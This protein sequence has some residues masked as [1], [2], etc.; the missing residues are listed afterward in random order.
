MNLFFVATLVTAGAILLGLLFAGL[1]YSLSGVALRTH[2]EIEAHSRSGGRSG[3]LAGGGP[4]F[5]PNVPQTLSA[6]L[7][8]ARVAAARIAA[9]VP[10]FGN[11]GIGRLE[12]T[13][14]VAD[15]KVA[16]IGAASGNDPLTATRIAW[17]HTRAGLI[18]VRPTQPGAAP[19]PAAT[20]AARKGAAPAANLPPAPQLIEITDSMPPEEVRK[21][22]IAN[23]KAKSAYNKL[24]KGMGVELSAAEPAAEVVSA[25]AVPAAAAAVAI[26]ADIPPAPTLI[27]ITDSMAP[28]EVRT[29]RI[30]NSKQLSAWKKE[31]KARGIDPASLKA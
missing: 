7:E 27:E 14:A 9:R 13:D 12:T 5:N 31:L 16:S 4:G 21:A 22:R 26:S 6:Q 25:A 28:E 3:I 8:E 23:S 18:Y 2:A 17:Y 20:G 30:N 19:A 29:A 24:L 10:R 11:Q 1:M 15:R